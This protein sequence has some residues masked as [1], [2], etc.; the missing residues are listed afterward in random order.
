[1][2]NRMY[3]LADEQGNYIAPYWTSYPKAQNRAIKYA[4]DG[5]KLHRIIELPSNDEVLG[6]QDVAK[7]VK[8]GF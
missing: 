8:M 6:F 2:R 1:M 4:K 7:L 3:A 5:G